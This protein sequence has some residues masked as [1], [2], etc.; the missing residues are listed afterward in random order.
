MGQ[1]LKQTTLKRELLKYVILLSVCLVS[2]VLLGLLLNQ[3]A[4]NSGLVVN[5]NYDERRVLEAE[6]L[7]E[8]AEQFSSRLIPEDIP[9]V[10]LDKH[11]LEPLEG[12]LDS[13]ATDAAVRAAQNPE[14]YQGQS[15]YRVIERDD[16]YVIVHYEVRSRFTIPFLRQYF[17]NYELT[18]ILVS[19]V[20][21]VGVV[22]A[23]TTVFARRLQRQFDLIQ[24]MTKRIQNQDLSHERERS[25]IKEFNDVLSS[26]QEMG[27]ALEDSL[28]AQW[29]TERRKREQISALA[30]DIK[31]PVTIIKG[32]AELLSLEEQSE[33]QATYTRYIVNASDRIEQ[34]VNMLMHL[35]KT[36]Q[37]MTIHMKPTLLQGFA[38]D[39][40]Q[41]VSGYTR[42]RKI[43]LD[44][45][46]EGTEAGEAM[47][48]K[49]LLHRALMNI[50]SNAV[51]Y[52]P[53]GGEIRLSYGIQN[54]ALSFRVTDTGPGFTPEG[55]KEAT[56]LF[57]MG[58]K[59]RTAKGHYGIGLTFANNVASLH[60]G[61]L[62]LRN[63]EP[64]GGAEVTIQIP[65][66]QG[67]K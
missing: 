65:L 16:V 9:Y 19:I 27:K 48:D 62:T 6:P 41:D 42:Q 25:P 32:N 45:N 15:V 24:A 43:K 26:L 38:A 23:V 53:D 61:T 36:E 39:L 35:S 20:S 66:R 21:I 14:A 51:D 17:P 40:I 31:I 29:R 13:S 7:I 2:V 37:D 8:E 64:Q 54:D 63:C 47:I 22:L 1:R 59:S 44:I 49:A 52:T 56:R 3:L 11:T 67:R 28:Q 55:L 33:D 30:H 60:H 5:A 12:T 4:I 34:Y 18:F 58:D 46:T 57:Y 10:V 50:I